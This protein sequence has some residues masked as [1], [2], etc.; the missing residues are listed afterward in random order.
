MHGMNMQDSIEKKH[1]NIC[2]ASLLLWDSSAQVKICI[3]Q[4][5]LKILISC[6][7]YEI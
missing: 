2:L 1:R 5:F 7:F 6:K 3:K 4:Y